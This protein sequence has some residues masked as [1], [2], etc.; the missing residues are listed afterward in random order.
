MEKNDFNMDLEE[1]IKPFLGI[2]CIITGG[3][4]CKIRGG[5][6][7]PLGCIFLRRQPWSFQS[8]SSQ[9]KGSSAYVQGNRVPGQR[10]LGV[11]HSVLLDTVCYV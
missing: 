3:P 7:V 5:R 4:G 1:C 9:V 8:H 11:K 10:L 6:G 2:A